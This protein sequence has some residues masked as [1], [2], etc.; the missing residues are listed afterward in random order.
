MLVTASEYIGAD[1]EKV[2]RFIV[3]AEKLADFRQSLLSALPALY[4][5]AAFPAWWNYS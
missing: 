5:L 3:R 2:K 1:L 4:E